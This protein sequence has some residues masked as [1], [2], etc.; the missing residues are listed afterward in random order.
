MLGNDY[1]RIIPYSWLACL[2]P[3]AKRDQVKVVFIRH[4]TMT[5][6]HHIGFPDSFT[7]L[8]GFLAKYSLV[9]LHGHPLLSAY[10]VSLNQQGHLSL[11][12]LLTASSALCSSLSFSLIQRLWFLKLSHR[13]ELEFSP[14]LSHCQYPQNRDE[15]GGVWNVVGTLLNIGDSIQPRK[16]E[17]NPIHTVN[18]HHTI[19]ELPLSH[20]LEPI[21][22]NLFCF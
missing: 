2:Y 10:L 9:S 7:N 1:Y 17:H 5:N 21:R 18:K 4:H 3:L 6:Y 20:T 14:L 15:L 13:L 8:S 11:P 19:Q 12:I 16:V 22:S